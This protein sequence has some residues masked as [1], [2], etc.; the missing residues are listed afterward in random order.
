MTSLD[1]YARLASFNA[2]YIPFPPFVAA[3]DAIEANLR[4]FRETGIAKHMLVVG[5]AG[6]GKSSLCRWLTRQYPQQ[7]LLDRDKIDVLAVPVP[8][9]ATVPG[10]IDAM[11]TAMGD[12]WHQKG[13]ATAKT[14][15]IVT[16]CRNCGVEFMLFDEAQ[17]LHDRGNTKTHYMVG[18]WLKHLIDEIGVP[19]TLLGLPRVEQLLLINDQLRRRFSSRV[20]LAM[21]QSD[22]LSVEAECLQLFLSLVSLIDIPVSSHPF[23]AQEMGE[24][25]YRSSDGRVAYIKRLLFAALRHALENDLEVIDAAMLEQVFTDEIWWEGV[26]KLNPFNPAFEFRRLDR[27]GEPFQLAEKVSNRRA[28]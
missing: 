1:L 23:S 9:S 7:R 10:I 25:L 13:T 17:H 4:L 2:Q 12:P 11:L 18:D 14:S 24:R 27:G 16:L 19:T 6:T 5:E 15:R 3:K 21:G 22:T 26:G 28:A 8:P 20:R